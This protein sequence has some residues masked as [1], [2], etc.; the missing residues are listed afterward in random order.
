[1]PPEIHRHLSWRRRTRF[2]RHRGGPLLTL[3]LII[4]ALILICRLPFVH[5]KKVKAAESINPPRIIR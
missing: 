5:E 3:A 2:L 4:V 1:M